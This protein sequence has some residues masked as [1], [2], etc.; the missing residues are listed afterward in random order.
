L[1]PVTPGRRKPTYETGQITA[2]DL[3]REGGDA[4]ISALLL[5]SDGKP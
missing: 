2:L 4:D 1:A 5:R 3:A